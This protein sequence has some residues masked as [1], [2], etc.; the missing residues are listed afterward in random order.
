MGQV[1]QGG[2]RFISNPV[3]DIDQ[4]TAELCD[5]VDVTRIDDEPPDDRLL[6][7]HDPT[8][9]LLPAAQEAGFSRRVQQMAE[10]VRP[11]PSVP[12]ANDAPLPLDEAS[13]E[14]MGEPVEVDTRLAAPAKRSRMKAAGHN[15]DR[16][17]FGNW[18]VKNS[19]PSDAPPRR[20]DAH[21]DAIGQ[22]GDLEENTI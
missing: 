4:D 6:P 2:H 5:A 21:A 12:P 13:A 20:D 14:V 22:P 7:P 10:T 11:K 18:K 8:T 1:G 19:P 9:D 16:C 17:L 15:K 3:Q